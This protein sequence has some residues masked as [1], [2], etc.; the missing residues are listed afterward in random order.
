MAVQGTGFIPSKM[1]KENQKEEKTDRGA[2]KQS[3]EKAPTADCPRSVANTCSRVDKD[4]RSGGHKLHSNASGT[5][6]RASAE[7]TSWLGDVSASPAQQRAG[8]PTRGYTGSGVKVLQLSGSPY[9]QDSRYF[10]N[11][12]FGSGM[13]DPLGGLSGQDFRESLALNSGHV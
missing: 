8:D 13:S 11:P 9:G 1:A 12:S 5:P 2:K 10:M 6:G 3:K 4:L 7:D